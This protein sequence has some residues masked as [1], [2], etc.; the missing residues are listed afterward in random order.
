MNFDAFL[1]SSY[2][3]QSIL[4]DQELTMNW[5]LEQIETG[6][7]PNKFALYP[8]P[9][10]T[11]FATC[12]ET[13]G[14]G[15]FHQ[16]GRMFSVAGA[17]LY[18]VSD[19]GLV[20]LLGS[21][22]L[23]ASP[24]TLCSSGQAGGELFVT[25]GDKGYILTLATNAFV[26][27]VDDVNFGGFLDGYFIGLDATSATMKISALLDGL[28]AWDAAQVA[29]RSTRGDKWVSMAIGHRL[30]YLFGTQ[31]ADIWYDSGISPFPLEPIQEAFMDAGGIL[32]PA[33]VALGVQGPIWLGRSAKGQATILRASLGG[34][35]ERVSHYGLENMINGYTTLTDAVAFTY[36]DRGHSFYVINF[37]TANATWVYDELLPP[38][39]GWHQRGTW[40]AP[41][42]RFDCWRPQYH[43]HAFGKHL[44]ADRTSGA[45]YHL[46]ASSYL[47]VDGEGIR[48]LRRAPAI[49]QEN[50]WI[51]YD[52]FALDME[53]GVG[54]ITGNGANPVV[55]LRW[56]DDGGH[57][58]SNE[59]QLSLGKIGEYVKRLEL[60]RL[61]R[62]RRRVWEVTMTDPVP[63]RI[64]AAYMDA[65]EGLS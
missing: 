36:E 4:A 54:T 52:R 46:T 19:A 12:P 23:D 45:I 62:A 50:K 41:L 32:A 18:E 15:M 10:L 5:Y 29:Q 28:T 47:D 14:R 2:Q 20:T 59:H 44:V 37:P 8:T 49:V 57:T 55:M 17:G 65:R 33:S 64:V 63:G 39:L 25:S 43:C 7:G 51:F 58:W 9:G 61:G 21:M 60:R 13:P 48:R 31:S 35:P 3:S 38:A 11:L 6:R 42:M 22:A 34:T 24:A 53:V 16:D 40:N 26:K 27:V 1:G 56:S 30:V